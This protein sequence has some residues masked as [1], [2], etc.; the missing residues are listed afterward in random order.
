MVVRMRVNLHV[1]IRAHPVVNLAQSIGSGRG[2]ITAAVTLEA[3]LQSY[4]YARC[5][6]DQT[7]VVHRMQLP[8]M[9]EGDTCE[10]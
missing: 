9:C 4:A 7:R 2:S 8:C 1:G 6:C 10:L 5:I 3:A